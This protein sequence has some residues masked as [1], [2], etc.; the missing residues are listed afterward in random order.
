MMVLDQQP[1]Q[2]KH[3]I[4]HSPA[5]HQIKQK[6][7]AAELQLVHQNKQGDT[8]ILAVMIEEGEAHAGLDK[9][10]QL[11]IKAEMTPMPLKLRLTPA[12]FMPGKSAYMRYSGSL[13][14]P[15]CTEGVQWVVM[16]APITASKQQ[17]TQLGTLL[18]GA[19]NRPIQATTG[20]MILE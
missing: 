13:T 20:R 10:I 17:L 14:S 4:L 6:N 5:E 8:V 19:N 7:Y 2:L 12:E 11:P 18:G 9:V 1:Y 15:P 3:I 16:K